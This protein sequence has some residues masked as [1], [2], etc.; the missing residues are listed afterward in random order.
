[1][2]DTWQPLKEGLTRLE[3]TRHVS[4]IAITL[5]TEPLDTSAPGYQPP[6]PPEMVKLLQESPPPRRVRGGSQHE[7]CECRYS[8]GGGIPPL[9]RWLCSA[10]APAGIGTVVLQGFQFSFNP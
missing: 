9:L 3:T 7:G 4:V 10:C 5:S 2:T 1:M 6:L 8:V